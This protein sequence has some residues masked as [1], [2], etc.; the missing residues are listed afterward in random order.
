MKKTFPV[1]IQGSVFYIDED[2]Y[3]LLNN[4]LD[5][6]HK[7]FPG[8]EGEEISSDIEARIGEIL[9]GNHPAG[10]GVVTIA[11][12]NSIIE[13]MGTP[14]DL[15]A[16]EN[17]DVNDSELHLENDAPT[18]PPL[19]GDENSS[20]RRR[21]FRDRQ[22][23]VLGGVLS[24]LACFLGWNVWLL[25]LFYFVATCCTCVWP[26]VLLYLLAWMI[27]PPATTRRDYLEMMG[28][29]V[30]IR[31][32]GL[33]FTDKELAPATNALSTVSSILG[34]AVLVALG[35]FCCIGL[36]ASLTYVCLRVW[37][38]IN[39]WS[40]DSM[41]ILSAFSPNHYNHNA[42][43]LVLEAL[44]SV[45]GGLA[46]VLVAVLTVWGICAAQFKTGRP[47]KTTLLVFAIII[48]LMLVAGGVLLF[49]SAA[50]ATYVM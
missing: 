29:P 10:S 18:P 35:L 32:I 1:N 19:E 22:N 50:S 43:S 27:I 14:Q 9:L 30:T 3:G 38:L 17:T 36:V 8:Q 37:G 23:R 39:F 34:K 45:I 7:A 25:R 28:R 12:V 24:G 15:G 2:A 48:A 21:L 40:W 41:N 33:T 47:A 5:Q 26:G 6:L 49:V 13:L 31:N 20:G 11:E 16:P 42:Q 46:L 44:G 4:Y